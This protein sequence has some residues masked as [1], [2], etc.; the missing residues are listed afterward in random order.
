MKKLTLTSLLFIATLASLGCVEISSAPKVP[1][2]DVVTLAKYREWTLVN[3]TPELMAPLP[4]ISCAIIPGR[5]EPSPH[6]HKYVSVFVNPVGREQMMTMLE[7]KFPVGSMI[8]KEKLGKPD[9]TTP[10]VLTVM[11]KREQGYNP[12]NGDWE[13]LVLDGTA[14]TIVERGKL[15]RCSGCHRSYK[16]SDFVTRTYLPQAVRRELKR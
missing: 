3:P 10:E 5:Q 1:E 7:P 9:S 8:V 13:Y 2:T 6:L 16:H 12:D 14:S 11:I 15:T 4:A